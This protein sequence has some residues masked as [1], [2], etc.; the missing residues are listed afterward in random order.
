MRGFAMGRDL[1][2]IVRLD[3]WVP[4]ECRL[5]CTSAMQAGDLTVILIAGVSIRNAVSSDPSRRKSSGHK[6]RDAENAALRA[7]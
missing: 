7:G 2:V 4:D 3:F 1:G 5:E 6:S